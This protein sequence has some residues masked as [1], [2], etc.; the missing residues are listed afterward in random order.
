MWA[1]Q[2]V[3]QALTSVSETYLI[4]III[5]INPLTARVLGAPQMILQPVSSNFPCSPLTSG[6]WRTPGL[7]VPWCCLPISSSVCLV[8]FPFHW[9]LQHG[10]GQTWWTGNMTIPLQFA[11]LY[12]GQRV[13]MWSDCLLDLGIDF[14]I[15]NM[16]FVWDALYNQKL[17]TAFQI[18]VCCS[19]NMLWLLHTLKSSSRVCCVWLVCF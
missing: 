19:S 10:F 4:I 2:N 12:N 16:V 18:I 1:K 7:S 6:T 15:D 3:F 17:Q 13:F 11:S 8:F 14:L 5:I 9:N